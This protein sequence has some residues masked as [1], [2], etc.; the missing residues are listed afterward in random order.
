MSLKLADEKQFQYVTQ[1]MQTVSFIASGLEAKVE[2]LTISANVGGMSRL[3]AQKCSN[4]TPAVLASL[5][6][7]PAAAECSVHVAPI[8]QAQTVTLFPK[9]ELWVILTVSRCQFEK[10]IPWLANCNLATADTPQSTT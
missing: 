8:M 1:R 4:L 7:Q 10:H 9:Q 3:V 6:F 2:K 5:C